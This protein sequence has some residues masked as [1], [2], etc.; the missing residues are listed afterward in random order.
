MVNFDLLSEVV[1]FR[2]RVAA[3]WKS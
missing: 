1:A 2:L 3:A